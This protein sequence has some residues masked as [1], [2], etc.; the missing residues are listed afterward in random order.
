MAS[1][2]ET[3]DKN[4]SGALSGL[5]VGGVTDNVANAL[6]NVLGE[7]IKAL[8]EWVFRA[9]KGIVEQLRT[10]VVS[11]IPKPKLDKYNKGFRLRVVN[12]LI[13]FITDL[14]LQPIFLLRVI[15][16]VFMGGAII[17]LVVVANLLLS[18]LIAMI[19][20]ALYIAG[21]MYFIFQTGLTI[22]IN[23]IF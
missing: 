19:P 8:L 18:L 22:A 1:G 12:A 6:R 15:A 17:D 13:I 14:L 11:K 4:F 16:S 3:F 10:A 21:H 2:N 5:G 9:E 7:Y 23:L 20:A